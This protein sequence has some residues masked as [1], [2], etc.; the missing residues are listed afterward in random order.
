VADHRDA[1]AGDPGGRFLE[2]VEGAVAD[3]HQPRLGREVVDEL[4]HP[5]PV[6][7]GDAEF[8]EPAL[9]AE[10]VEATDRER[11]ARRQLAERDR[12][13]EAGEALVE[14]RHGLA[15]AEDALAPEDVG[16]H[17]HAALA[18][19]GRARRSRQRAGGHDARRSEEEAPH[20]GPSN[21]TLRGPSSGSGGAT[22]QLAARASANW[23]MDSPT[24]G[25]S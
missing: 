8:G 9:A 18:H 10:R 22:C 11:L 20:G 13:V 21:Q 3:E 7:G 4:G 24:R 16:A 14:D 6:L 2:L 19:D 5:H 1:L 23:H 12:A 17:A 15:L 25:L